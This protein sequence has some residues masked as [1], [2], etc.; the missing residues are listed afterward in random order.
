[1]NLNSK[2]YFA[3]YCY[4][5]SIN[6]FFT[7]KKKI[8]LKPGCWN[9]KIHRFI[10]CISHVGRSCISV[11]RTYL[12]VSPQKGICMPSRFALLEL[13][14]FHEYVIIEMSF[15]LPFLLSRPLSNLLLWNI[16]SYT[17][18]VVHTEI[19]QRLGFPTFSYS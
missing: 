12:S 11:G 16:F 10:G 7:K 3:L 4:R 19:H 17:N 13:W 18:S 15:L 1:M 5:V 8:Y 14:V 6:C 2:S 9:R